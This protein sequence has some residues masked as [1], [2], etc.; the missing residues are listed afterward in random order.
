MAYKYISLVVTVHRNILPAEVALA[1]TRLCQVTSNAAH[2]GWLF[3]ATSTTNDSF[4]C[5]SKYMI[6]PCFF[7]MGVTVAI[8]VYNNRVIYVSMVTWK[9]GITDLINF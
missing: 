5:I 7:K 9:A 2:E 4:S 1:V 8:S 3:H 6:S